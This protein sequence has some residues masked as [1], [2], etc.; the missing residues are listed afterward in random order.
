MKDKETLHR[1]AQELVD[2][3]ATT[4]PLKE[5]SKLQA[6]EG[7]EEAPIKWLALA[8][9]HGIN[10]NAKE[11]SVRKLKD[12]KVKVFAEY[13]ESELPSPGTAIGDK[14]FESLRGITHLEGEKDETVLAM[15]VREG[16]VDLSL[17]IKRDKSGEEEITLKF[18]RQ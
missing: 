5:M 6:E 2:C 16:S 8:V 18:P 1:K 15:G 17:K 9:L 10:A 12:G 14:I 7:R 3:F 11:I 4:D 13:R